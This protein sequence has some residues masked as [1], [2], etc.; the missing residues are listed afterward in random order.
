MPDQDLEKDK[1]H[2]ANMLMGRVFTGQP[3]VVREEDME[4]FLRLKEQFESL[5]GRMCDNPFPNG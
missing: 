5:A 1:G 2:L 3:R 4:L